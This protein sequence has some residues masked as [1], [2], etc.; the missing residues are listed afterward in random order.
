MNSMLCGG[1]PAQVTGICVFIFTTQHAEVLQAVGR[2]GLIRAQLVL[3]GLYGRV[4]GNTTL[5]GELCS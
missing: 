1:P 2:S 5:T 4:L 3:I